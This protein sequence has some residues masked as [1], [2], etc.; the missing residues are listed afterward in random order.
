MSAYFIAHFNITDPA[1]FEEYK[2]N[3]G[4]TLAGYNVKL[5]A[6]DGAVEVPEGKAPGPITVMLEFDTKEKLKEW[7]DSP[8]Y[9]AVLPKRLGA[10][11]GFTVF[12]QGVEAPKG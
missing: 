7:Y 3:A 8:A 12:V 4:A 2:A 1:M 10:T 6:V 5:L 11:E 9:R